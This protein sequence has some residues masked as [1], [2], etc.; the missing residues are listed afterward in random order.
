MRTTLTENKCKVLVFVVTGC[1][2]FF[3][4][5][6]LFSL[7]HSKQEIN[8]LPLNTSTPA[9][10]CYVS[11]YCVLSIKNLFLDH[12]NFYVHEVVARYIKQICNMSHDWMFIT[13]DMISF[14]HIGFAFLGSKLVCSDS[15]GIR[16]LGVAFFELRN[17]MDAMDGTLARARMS[18]RTS[19][20]EPISKTIAANNENVYTTPREVMHNSFF[21][22]K[23]GYYIDGIC[24]GIGCLALFCAC[25]L[26]LKNHRFR[27]RLSYQPL[28]L[29]MS[30]RNGIKS[31]AAPNNGNKLTCGRKNGLL[32]SRISELQ[33]SA[34]RGLPV[35]F[36]GIVSLISSIFWNLNINRYTKFFTP[37]QDNH[38]TLHGSVLQS[39][40]MWL[41]ITSWRVFNPQA[42]IEMLLAAI[43]IDRLQDFVYLMQYFGSFFVCATIGITEVH[44]WGLEFKV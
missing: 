11:P 5:L 35:I 28:S 14:G 21:G 34:G 43:F 10:P 13:P 1:T 32:C 24:D 44:Y 26:Y 39:F 20:T 7:F 18:S 2:Y 25:F 29:V 8:S 9:N 36:F 19:I 23:A 22:R 31:D 38:K 27:R 4:D 15:L 16:R 3:S 17:F 37:V 12:S 40:D 42:L 30:T 33:E 41:I 6:Y